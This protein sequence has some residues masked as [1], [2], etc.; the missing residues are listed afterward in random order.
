MPLPQ[1]LPLIIKMVLSI[2][3]LLGIIVLFWPAINSSIIIYIDK[4][5]QIPDIKQTDRRLQFPD[6]GKDY[7][8]PV[9]VANSFLFLK[10]H[11][12]NKVIL[13]QDSESELPVVSCQ[14]LGELMKTKTGPGTST[15]NF[16]VG[17]KQYI[18]TST[19]YS[20]MS[21]KYR[22]WNRHPREFDD[23]QAVP[24]LSF[25]KHG[26]RDNRCE[27]LNIG[28]YKADPQKKE[29]I[30]ESGH[31]V[32]LVGY[33]IGADGVSNPNTL[34]VR[35]PEPVLSEES[36]KI[37]LTVGELRDGTLKGPHEGL[38]RAAKGYLQIKS[39]GNGLEDTSHHR[40]GIIDGAIVLELWPVLFN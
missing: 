19:P 4:V 6:F 21:L 24:D 13:K 18:E 38:P 35:D 11:G 12:Y 32:T 22:G 33:G 23:G 39:M 37:F 26:I 31:W 8:A 28:W 3:F 36:R 25:V 20:I 5:E 17:L 30:R 9:V 40:I 15:E 1:R 34:I 29:L 7:C 14:R 10:N 27:W 2:I 16:L